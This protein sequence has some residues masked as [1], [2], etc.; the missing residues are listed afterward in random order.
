M[1]IVEAHATVCSCYLY[2]ERSPTLPL[3]LKKGT[4]ISVAYGCATEPALGAFDTD[5]VL[6]FGVLVG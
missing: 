5:E 4:V 2:V 3:S 1:E 6:M